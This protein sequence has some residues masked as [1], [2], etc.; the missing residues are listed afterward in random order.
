MAVSHHSSDGRT[1]LEPYLHIFGFWH[2]AERRRRHEPHIKLNGISLSAEGR[3]KE[4]RRLCIC[5]LIVPSF[6]PHGRVR[7]WQR[8]SM[9]SR[10]RHATFARRA[11]AAA[12]RAKRL[13]GRVCVW[14]TAQVA[15]LLSNHP[16]KRRPN[17]LQSTENVRTWQKT[18]PTTTIATATTAQY[19]AQKAVNGPY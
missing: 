6:Q 7:E 2:S 4:K 5:S 1:H 12:W 18:T 8:T 19:S 15:G 14:R 10:R 3:K 16:S 9:Q 13:N 17:A 11:A